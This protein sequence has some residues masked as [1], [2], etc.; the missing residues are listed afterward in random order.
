MTRHETIGVS[1]WALGV[2]AAA[3][4]LS[5]WLA[6]HKDTSGSFPNT[7]AALT[8]IGGAALMIER[9]IEVFWTILGGII[10]TFWPLNTVARQVMEMETDLKN[11]MTPF[12]A[13]AKE[14]LNKL[15]EAENWTGAAITAAGAEIDTLQTRLGQISAY[16]ASNQRYQL[17]V[18]AAAQNVKY[19]QA[20]Y[21][22]VRPDLARDMAVADSAMSGLKDFLAGFK[23]NPGRRLISIYLGCL[24]GLLVAGLY[25]LDAFAAAL[26]N[27]SGSSLS[28]VF[29]GLLIG[30]GANPTHEVIRAIQEYK[31][32]QKGANA[33]TP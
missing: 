23:D 31:K 6:S 25:H 29:T 28:I 18:A 7:S 19:L 5:A 11:A 32:S 13:S 1:L 9:I 20:K 26:G 8:F 15:A 2:L 16:P 21:G 33:E 24:L 22:A 30:L 17:L 4:A 3:I 10:G 27:T 12:Y 14:G